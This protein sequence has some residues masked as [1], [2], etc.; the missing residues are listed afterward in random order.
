[1][2]TILWFVG[3]CF[4][5]EKPDIWFCLSLK[6]VS[7]TREQEQQCAESLASDKGKDKDKTMVC[8]LGKLEWANMNIMFLQCKE[9]I[10][11]A[12]LIQ[13]EQDRLCAESL[14]SYGPSQKQ[15]EGIVHTW[16]AEGTQAWCVS[17]WLYIFH[18]EY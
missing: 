17:P 5:T 9:D 3:I 6:H 13:A 8:W 2:M 14:S 16:Q 7:L 4:D 1:M 11:E 12:R 10:E 18:G 15:N